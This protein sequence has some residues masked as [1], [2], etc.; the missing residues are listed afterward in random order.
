MLTTLVSSAKNVR[1][2]VLSPDRMDSRVHPAEI[3][4]N[5]QGNLE[6]SIRSDC[7]RRQLLFLRREA[8]SRYPASGLRAPDQRH[9]RLRREPMAPEYGARVHRSLHRRDAQ[10]CARHADLSRGDF[11]GLVRLDV[12]ARVH[13]PW[14]DA[15]DEPRPR[16]IGV[17]RLFVIQVTLAHVARVDL[18]LVRADGASRAEARDSRATRVGRRHIADFLIVPIHHPRA[19]HRPP[20]E[21]GDAK[22]D[23]RPDWPFGWMDVEGLRHFDGTLRQRL[24]RLGDRYGMHAAEV[25]RNIEMG[26]ESPAGVDLR[27]SQNLRAV[28]EPFTLE[29]ITI[30]DDPA[31]VDGL[32]DQIDCSVWRQ[33]GRDRADLGAR[34]RFG[35]FHGRQR[36]GLQRGGR[37]FLR[38]GL[39]AF[40]LSACGCGN[41]A[42]ARR[43]RKDGGG[44]G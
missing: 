25:F 31:A 20:A 11:L 43:Q 40:A 27:S 32:P 18:D 28:G 7:E 1:A 36:E 30:L 16:Q 29:A 35:R 6:A 26:L 17:W 24:P 34:H 5:H 39:S 15:K 14:R 38:D 23:E 22:L 41:R 37:C 9:G 12:S 8:V 4:R 2:S 19:L 13:R 42:S 33:T 10:A 3:V 44:K 21:P